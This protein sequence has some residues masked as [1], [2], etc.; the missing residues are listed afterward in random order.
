VV[1]TLETFKNIDRNE[2]LHV[3]ET[4]GQASPR[5]SDIYLRVH[6]KVKEREP[7]FVLKRSFNL[8]EA[9]IS[10]P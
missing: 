5:G 8:K 7:P 9:S 2:N 3:L 10:L 6:Y 4:F 1:S